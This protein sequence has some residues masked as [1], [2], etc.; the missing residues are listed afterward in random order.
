MAAGEAG[1]VKA[2]VARG[3]VLAPLSAQHWS[4]CG[5]WGRQRECAGTAHGAGVECLHDVLQVL[6]V[7]C[8]VQARLEHVSRAKI[9]TCVDVTAGR[10]G[11][12]TDFCNCRVSALSKH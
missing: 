1:S 9:R 2:E 8:G 4:F 11:C 5:S 6:A 7:S 10:T 3:C 12:L